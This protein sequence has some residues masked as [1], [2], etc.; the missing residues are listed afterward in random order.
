MPAVYRLCIFVQFSGVHGPDSPSRPKLR[1]A[2]ST[3]CLLI[4][5]FFFN[6]TTHNCLE[7]ILRIH[8]HL[9]G[10]KSGPRFLGVFTIHT[11]NPGIPVR[12]H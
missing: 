8:L 5:V 1:C 9:G 7:T 6:I 10:R 12:N 3:D 2:L 11:E 4:I